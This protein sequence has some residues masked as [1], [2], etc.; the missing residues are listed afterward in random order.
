MASPLEDRSPMQTNE[1]KLSSRRQFLKA[2]GGVAAVSALAGA[3]VPHVHA[4]GSDQIQVA[5]VG[6]GGRGSGA[7]VNA[8]STSSGPIKLVAMA[9][10]YPDRLQSSYDNLSR[11][12][13]KQ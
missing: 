8:L 5:L 6:C 13:G 7:A 12:V 3:T 2:T 11:E 1:N 10:A 9:D 4:A